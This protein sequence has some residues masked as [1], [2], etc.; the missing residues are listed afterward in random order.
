MSNNVLI[1]ANESFN[2]LF[3]HQFIDYNFVVVTN[4]YFVEEQIKT[5]ESCFC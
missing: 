2:T 4:L 3:K 5:H 1:P